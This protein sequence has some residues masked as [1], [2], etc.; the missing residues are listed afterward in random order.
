MSISVVIELVGFLTIPESCGSL[1]L[2]SDSSNAPGVAGNIFEPS[3]TPAA[4]AAAIPASVRRYNAGELYLPPLR[5]TSGGL[6]PALWAYH[7]PFK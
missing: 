4:S 2:I 5:Y 6:S 1:P 7:L 3:A